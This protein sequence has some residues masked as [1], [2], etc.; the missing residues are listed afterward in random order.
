[1][2]KVI[3]LSASLLTALYIRSVFLFV[4]YPL[5]K[6]GCYEKNIDKKAQMSSV[7]LWGL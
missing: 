5:K 1:V 2:K 3:V 4:K 7:T 6:S